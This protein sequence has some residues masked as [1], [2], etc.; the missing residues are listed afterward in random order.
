MDNCNDIFLTRP[1]VWNMLLVNSSRT[2]VSQSSVPSY[3]NKQYV[4]R[5][6]PIMFRNI[7]PT[8]RMCGGQRRPALS[9]A[10][11]FDSWG[12]TRSPQ[13]PSKAGAEREGGSPIG[14]PSSAARRNKKNSS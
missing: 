9:A 5:G 10:W 3:T 2:V 7:A 6:I 12:E 8:R 1:K 11:G 4:S 14:A 13:M